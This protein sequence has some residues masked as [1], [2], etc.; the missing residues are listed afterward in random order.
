MNETAVALTLVFTLLGIPFL[1]VSIAVHFYDIVWFLKRSLKFLLELPTAPYR[2][3]KRNKQLSCHHMYRKKDGDYSSSVVIYRYRCE[4]C[5][6]EKKLGGEAAK[7]F[8][9]DFLSDY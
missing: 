5:K 1:I 4:K 8:E 3:Y 2:I 6:A 9:E 7:K